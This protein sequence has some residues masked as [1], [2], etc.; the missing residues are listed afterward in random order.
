VT[1]SNQEVIR[2]VD[3]NFVQ[4]RVE[5]LEQRDMVD[6]FRMEWTPCVVILNSDGEEQYRFVG[7][8]S[9]P[10]F[11]AHLGLGMARLAFLSKDFVRAAA[12][13]DALVQELPSSYVAPEAIWY[14]GISNFQTSGDLT[15]LK[16]TRIE[17]QKNYPQSIWGEKA[18]AWGV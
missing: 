15:I 11:I 1:Y 13:F 5:V 14:R 17:L 4:W 10:E 9:P 18:S 6:R 8:L 16:Q 3:Q 12:L 2:Y 7:F